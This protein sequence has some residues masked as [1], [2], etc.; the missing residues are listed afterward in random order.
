ML[1]TE[2]FLSFSAF[3]GMYFSAFKSRD[4]FIQLN[5][6]YHAICGSAGS[7]FQAYWRE[8]NNIE[9]GEKNDKS[10]GLARLPSSFF[11]FFF[12]SP[13]LFSLAHHHL[14]AWNRIF[15]RHERGRSFVDS[16]SS[17]AFSVPIVVSLSSA[18]AFYSRALTARLGK[19]ARRLGRR[20]N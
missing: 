6:E 9:S 7:V 15:R 13:P 11:F 16:F 5:M 3:I 17:Y 8:T 18:E 20:K 10:L 14:N 12:K 1:D 4:I 2:T 19:N